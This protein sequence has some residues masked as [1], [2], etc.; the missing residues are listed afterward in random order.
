MNFGHV[1]IFKN[2]NPACVPKMYWTHTSKVHAYNCVI[3]T[4]KKG[5]LIFKEK[6]M[7]LHGDNKKHSKKSSNSKSNIGVISL[8]PALQKTMSQ[9][10][11]FWFKTSKP[12]GGRQGTSQLQRVHRG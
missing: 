12:K 10:P 4:L 7:M 1:R 3:N 8:I 2:L 9:T 5:G 6:H 11:Y